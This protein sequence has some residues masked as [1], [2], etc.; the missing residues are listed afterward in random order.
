M[1]I[2]ATGVVL[3]LATGCSPVGKTHSDNLKNIGKYHVVWEQPSKNSLG[4]M[5]MGNGDL[6]INLWVEENGDLQFYLSKTDAWSENARLLKL[7][8]VRLRLTPN[9]FRNGASYRQ[10]LDVKDGLLLI[11]AGEKEQQVSVK[12]WV[13][14]HHPTV[15]LSV[16]S[17]KPITAEVTTEPWRTER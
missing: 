3:C 15:E 8:K 17:K 12:I 13:D 9:P 1:N 2:W 6:G 5:P 14:A 4:N 10:T 7:G 11:D 16:T